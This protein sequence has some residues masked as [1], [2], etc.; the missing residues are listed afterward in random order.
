MMASVN[1]S[2]QLTSP[3]TFR[4]TVIEVGDKSRTRAFMHRQLWQKKDKHTYVIN[5]RG[6]VGEDVACGAALAEAITY[7]YMHRAG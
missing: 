7:T 5:I 3:D 6:W 2:P 4:P 1:A